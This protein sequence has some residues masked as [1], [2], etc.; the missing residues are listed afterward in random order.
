MLNVSD[1]NLAFP[2]WNSN[3]DHFR[4][5]GNADQNIKTYRINILSLKCSHESTKYQQE[6]NPIR[7]TG[8]T[9]RKTGQIFTDAFRHT[10]S[11]V[12]QSIPTF[13]DEDKK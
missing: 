6:T 1:K 2:K 3:F 8:K 11:L 10:P 9:T 4:L 12:P 13:G 5:I 7:W